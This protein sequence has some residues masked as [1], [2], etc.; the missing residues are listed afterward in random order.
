MRKIFFLMILILM[1]VITA[2]C[3]NLSSKERGAA[4]GGVLGGTVAILANSASGLKLP[5][6]VLAGGVIGSLLAKD[7]CTYHSHTQDNN[8]T[9][10]AYHP[11]GGN[12]SND[13]TISG[14]PNQIPTFHV[15][16]DVQ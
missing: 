11:T 13:C 5:A 9:G 16:G 12:A 14:S 7:P 8:F 10:G 15:P 4:A 1:L 6:A 3:A 2:G